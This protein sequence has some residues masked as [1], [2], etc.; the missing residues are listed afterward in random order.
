RRS[1]SIVPSRSI[2]RPASNYLHIPRQ[3][4]FRNCLTSTETEVQHPRKRS[5]RKR[6]QKSWNAP[7]PDSLPISIYLL[8]YEPYPY[9]TQPGKILGVYSTFNAVTTA[10]INHGAYAFS[11]E[12]MLDGS[13]YLNPTGKIRI[14]PR[15]IQRHGLEVPL[16]LRHGNRS[17]MQLELVSSNVRRARSR[18]TGDPGIDTYGTV[19]AVIHQSP[20]S[21]VC[22]G[23][24]ASRQRAWGACLKS[25]AFF[26]AKVRLQDEIR[27]ID[28][29]NMPRTRGRIPGV[30]IHEWSVASFKVD[31]GG[32]NSARKYSSPPV[33]QLLMFR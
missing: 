27:W 22:M 28:E 3:I 30:G 12:G 11:R 18:T 4:S 1:A 8:H 31:D 21:S 29:D 16:P 15:E 14:V 20:E 5:S 24:F 25:Q 7:P 26:C 2:L 33:P 6:L 17:H 32:K 9:T 10:A 23:V 19:F 13:E